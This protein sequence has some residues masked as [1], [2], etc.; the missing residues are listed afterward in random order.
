MDKQEKRRRWKR[1]ISAL[2]AG[3]LACSLFGVAGAEAFG[4]VAEPA[5]GPLVYDEVYG[6][7]G[8]KYALMSKE[9]VYSAQYQGKV[10]E[11]VLV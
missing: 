9:T 4:A 10:K 7:F 8:G 3:V 6:V 11:Y 5:G 2:L 1:G